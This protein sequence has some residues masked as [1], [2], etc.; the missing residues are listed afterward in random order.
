MRIPTMLRALRVNR[1][2]QSFV[3]TV[4]TSRATQKANL[5]SSRW[6]PL[7]L[8]PSTLTFDLYYRVDFSTKPIASSECLQSALAR[9][10]TV[11][12]V[13]E[14]YEVHRESVYSHNVVRSCLYYSLRAAQSQQLSSG[15]LFEVPGF[16]R[17]WS[18]LMEEVPGMSANSA[19]KCLYNCAQ[20]DFRHDLLSASLV[21]VCTQKSRQIPSISIG[22]LLWSLKRLDLLTSSSTS[23]LVSHLVDLFHAKVVSGERFKTQ[24]LANILWALASSGNLPQHVGEKVTQVLP[25]YMNTFDFHSLSLCLWSLTTGGATLSKSL[26]ESAGSTAATFLKRERSVR[27]TIHCCWTFALAE[28]YHKPFCEELSRLILSEPI[29]S[30]LFT[31]RLLGSVAWMCAR[32]GYFNPALLDCIATRALGKLGHFNSQD[33]G[34]LMYAYAQLSYPHSQLVGEV[35]ERF[36]SDDDLLRD[37][38]ACVG[39]AWANLAV[40]EYPLPLLKHLM[41]P[42]RVRCKSNRD[43][44]LH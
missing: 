35:T 15:E 25:R 27:N 36:V 23:H 12:E 18:H 1:R 14:V 20:F 19:I 44:Q 22:I 32:V 21:D 11:Y 31:P 29:N 30:P 38:D 8:K 37:G 5:T 28:F 24:S 2:A 33:L 10:Q 3:R 9:T 34:N 7:L 4:W 16:D 42:Q 43:L 17:F 26:L 13:L 41:E 40:G 39:I 6:L